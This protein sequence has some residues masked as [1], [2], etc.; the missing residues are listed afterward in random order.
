MS[1]LLT[2]VEKFSW[3]FD[4]VD[5]VGSAIPENQVTQNFGKLE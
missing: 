4:L 3:I 1:W 2:T 5:A